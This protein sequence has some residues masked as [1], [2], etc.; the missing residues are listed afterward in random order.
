VLTVLCM[1]CMRGGIVSE[2]SVELNYYI[3]S[4]LL[5][6]SAMGAPDPDV[7]NPTRIGF[8]IET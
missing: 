8:A 6:S 4:S 5:Q 2:F 3:I 7:L 1:I